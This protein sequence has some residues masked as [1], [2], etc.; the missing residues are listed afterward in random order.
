MWL[1]RALGEVAREDD[2]HVRRC[3]CYGRLFF[4]IN[5]QILTAQALP[6]R[7]V[8]KHAVFEFLLNCLFDT[9]LPGQHHK[10][11]G[12]RLLSQFW[13]IDT[14]FSA[15]LPTGDESEIDISL[16]LVETWIEPDRISD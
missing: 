1:F 10:L 5:I 3:A 8:V 7:Q 13:L 4:D 11:P 2:D 14:L 9:A 15:P 16:P 6:H 12:K